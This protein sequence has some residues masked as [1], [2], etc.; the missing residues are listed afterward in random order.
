[1]CWF[2][3]KNCPVAHICQS[4]T[5]LTVLCKNKRDVKRIKAHNCAMKGKNSRPRRKGRPK[6]E[7]R[8]ARSVDGN[9]DDATAAT[10]SATE[11]ATTSTTTTTATTTNNDDDN[12][13]GD[14]SIDDSTTVGL[15]LN[16]DEAQYGELVDTDTED[17]LNQPAKEYTRIIKLHNWGPMEKV[18]RKKQSSFIS[19]ED[20]H[21]GKSLSS[22]MRN[23]DLTGLEAANPG[24]TRLCELRE[25]AANAIK[26]AEK[27]CLQY[28]HKDK[29]KRKLEDT[30]REYEVKIQQYW[31]QINNTNIQNNVFVNN[32]T[33]NI[34]MPQNQDQVSLPVSPFHSP[35]EMNHVQGGGVNA[36]QQSMVRHTT[37]QL[38]SMKEPI[39]PTKVSLKEP[40]ERLQIQNNLQQNVINEKMAEFDEQY[41]S[42]PSEVFWLR[43]YNNLYHSKMKGLKGNTRFI[44]THLKHKGNNST[45][46]LGMKKNELMALLGY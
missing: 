38:M 36:I 23:N 13:D 44:E 5:R 1:M 12:D 25:K 32:N 43:N 29:Y 33:I 10:T 20:D 31:I 15:T 6:G 19:E 45:N 35:L 28:P 11:S 39:T 26:A 42:I 22:L 2:K 34:H 24:A 9:N 21:K 30:K 17:E 41:K 4:Y 18:E 14:V 16:D 37:Q 8:R 46:R 7:S 27:L 40:P 3:N